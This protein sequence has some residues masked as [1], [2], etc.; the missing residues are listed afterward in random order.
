MGQSSLCPQA[1]LPPPWASLPRL[2]RHASHKVLPKT[3]TFGGFLGTRSG[4]LQPQAAMNP[5]A[6][7]SQAE[8]PPLGSGLRS[9]SGAAR[10]WLRPGSGLAGVWLGTGL[11]PGVG[12]TQAKQWT[13]FIL[14]C[15]PTRRA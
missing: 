14:S 9:S 3:V 8:A 5:T 4:G 11:G 12:Y 10:V 2:R 15:S 7:W 13:H 6:L 1:L